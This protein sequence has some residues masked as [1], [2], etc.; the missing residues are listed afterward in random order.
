MTGIKVFLFQP[1]HL[2]AAV[3]ETQNIPLAS[4][5]GP[6]CNTSPLGT[7]LE[8]LLDKGKVFIVCVLL[9]LCA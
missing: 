2:A 3:P 4:D 6:N 1:E 7:M 9:L 8:L 5:V